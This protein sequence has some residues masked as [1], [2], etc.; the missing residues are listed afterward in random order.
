MPEEESKDLTDVEQFILQA[1]DFETL[2]CVRRAIQTRETQLCRGLKTLYP[3]GTHLT[4]DHKGVWWKGEVKGHG[5]T[6]LTVHSYEPKVA[7]WKLH[8]QGAR[9]IETPPKDGDEK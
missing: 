9:K 5:R 8:P 7:R 2:A 1:P 6:R 3:K 4:W